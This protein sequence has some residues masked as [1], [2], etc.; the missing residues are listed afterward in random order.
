M[1]F[2]ITGIRYFAVFMGGFAF[3]DVPGQHKVTDNSDHQAQI[4]KKCHSQP[5][6]PH[7]GLHFPGNATQ[8]AQ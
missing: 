2:A 8:H 4:D 6:E 3:T 5:V 7:C 1:N